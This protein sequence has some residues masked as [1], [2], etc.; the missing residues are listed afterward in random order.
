MHNS[1]EVMNEIPMLIILGQSNA[2]GHGTQLPIS[3]RINVPLSNVK[4][5]SRKYNQQYGL[6]EL[7]WS[8]YTSYDMNLGETQDHT[9]C[10]ATEFA[11]KWQSDIDSKIRKAEDLYIV[12]ISV[13]G[14][15]IAKEEVFGNMWYPNR[16]KIMKPGKLDEVNISLYPFVIE[17][18]DRMKKEFFNEGKKLRIIG[19]HWN[20]WETEVMTGGKAIEEA[21]INYSSLFKGFKEVLGE[22]P[23]YLYRPLTEI[24][25]NPEA[26]MQIER[27]FHQLVIENQLFKIIDLSKSELWKCDMKNKGIYQDD[28]VHY[29]AEVQKWLANYQYKE[30][31]TQGP[32]YR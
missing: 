1:N 29:T 7:T 4:G 9:V 17:I 26:I 22:I 14:Q 12:Q 27:V 11:R 20:Q 25:Q 32:D 21:Y 31:D 30:I 24:Y 6:R 23:I 8:G 15:G 16:N 10:L 5:L 13:G 3:E 2:H 18:F 28:G 19:L